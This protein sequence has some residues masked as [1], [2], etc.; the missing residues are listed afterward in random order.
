MTWQTVIGLEVHVQLNT[1]AKLFSG[2]AT[3]Y[4]AASNTQVNFL[5]AGLPGTLPV[6]NHQ[7]VDLAIK[8]GLA[9]RATINKKNV[10]SRKNY[11]YPDLPKGYQITQDA[12]P[13]IQGG[14]LPIQI[15]EES[16]SVAMTR[17]HLEEDA[18][19]SVHQGMMPGY[20]GVDLNRAGIPLLEIVSEPVL[21]SAQEAVAL[22]K[23]IHTLIRYLEI[24]T[25]N[26]QEGAMRC[27]ANISVRPNTKAP[28]GTRV[29][30][31]NINSFKFVEKAIEYEVKRQTQLIKQG[32]SVDQETRLYDPNKNETRSMRSKEDAQDYRY[33]PDPDLPILLLEDDYIENIRATL[34]ELPW[35]KK[36]RFIESFK[37]SAYD[38]HVLTQDKAL[39]EY[40]E[41]MINAPISKKLAANWLSVEL[42]T[43]LNQ[44]S[45]SIKDSPISPKA[46]AALVARIEDK[47]LSGKMAKDALAHLWE[48]PSLSIDQIIQEKGLKQISDD[49]TLLPMIE[50]LLAAHPEQ[51]AAFRGGK[52]KLFGFFVGQMMKQ[53]KGQANPERINKLLR[54]Q[55]EDKA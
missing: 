17:A 35:Q 5:D 14:Q 20:S 37:L 8:M 41:Q 52:D 4:D 43:Y 23:T 26:M 45:L 27:D 6:L 31:K 33:F 39:A 36:Q 16:R 30:I 53:T 25:G 47:T 7:A 40:Y 44:H 24:S 22:L 13:I 2:S 38:A 11:F 46:L 50:A 12:Y 18:G 55:L 28:L 49:Q 34:P 15:G 51:V 3:R 1:D 21:Y 48:N 32:G 42:Q 29:E 9:M 54:E 19:K 10:F